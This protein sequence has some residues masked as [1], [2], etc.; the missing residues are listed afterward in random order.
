MG[1]YAYIGAKE[2]LGVCQEETIMITCS[3][4]EKEEGKCVT[5]KESAGAPRVFGAPRSTRRSAFIVGV[6][7]N[8]LKRVWLGGKD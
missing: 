5:S 1:S 8:V 7:I 3:T 6:A 4:C 2:V